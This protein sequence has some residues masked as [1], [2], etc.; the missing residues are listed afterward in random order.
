MGEK[1]TGEQEKQTVGQL[2]RELSQ[3]LQALYREQLGQ[4]PEKATCQLFSSKVAV[5]LEGAVTQ[6]ERL[7]A[8]DGHEELAEQVRTDLDQAMRPRIQQLVEEVLGVEV[9][10]LLSDAA[11]DSGRTAIII[12]LASPPDVRNPEA[13]PK[14]KNK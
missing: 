9:L 4:R 5:L 2:E 8:D 3:K 7:L 6:P 14:T 13:I 1:D 10:E 11:L 12:I